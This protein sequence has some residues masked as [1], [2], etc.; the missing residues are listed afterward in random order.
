MEAVVMFSVVGVIAAVIGIAVHRTAARRREACRI[1]ANQIS[2]EFRPDFPELVADLSAGGLLPCGTSHRARNAL[3]GTRGSMRVALADLSYLSGS[4]SSRQSHTESICVLRRPG[5]GL[6][7]FTVQGRSPLLDALFRAV[8]GASVSIADDP[9]F[10][11]SFLVQGEDEVATRLLFGPEVRSRL[12]QLTDRPVRIAGGGDML[13][14]AHR[15]LVPPPELR[16][17]LANSTE[18]LELFSTA[19]TGR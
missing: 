14:L 9:E 7:W 4:G 8:G 11:R 10:S 6:T 5:L 18:L 19:P 16:G 12:L 1:V 15:P 3:A 17:M 2:L 13:V